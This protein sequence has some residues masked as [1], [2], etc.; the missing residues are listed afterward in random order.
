MQ[1]RMGTASTLD[2]MTNSTQTRAAYYREQAQELREMAA[3]GRDAELGR[4]LFDIAAKY[5][6]LADSILLDESLMARRYA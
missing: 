1:G 5:D 6:A 4:D 2:V 3:G